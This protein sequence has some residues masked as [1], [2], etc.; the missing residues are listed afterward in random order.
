V[1][2]VTTKEQAIIIA[3]QSATVLVLAPLD[4]D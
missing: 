2:N 1:V 3:T 4:L